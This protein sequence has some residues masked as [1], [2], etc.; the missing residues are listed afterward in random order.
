[1]VH[2]PFQKTISY[3]VKHHF[4]YQNNGWVFSEYF[5][6][7]YLCE[8]W[9][10]YYLP[11]DVNGLTVLDVGA[12]CGESARFFL[13]HGAKKVICIE[14]DNH[15]Y[16]LLAKN[17]IG[18]PMDCIHKM[19]SLSDLDRDF[20][21]IK[22]DIEGAEKT[23][24]LLP[25]KINKPIALEVHGESLAKEFEKKG[26]ILKHIIDNDVVKNGWLCYAY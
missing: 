17:A 19:F 21:F 15:C 1:M 10:K 22:M 12:G 18:R 25:T 2:F 20:D 9:N 16:S 4:L 6:K 23:L 7:L 24:L 8:D 14:S 11:V 5:K 3:F 26:Y 13:E